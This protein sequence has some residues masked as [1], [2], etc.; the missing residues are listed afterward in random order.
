[1]A[2]L[3]WTLAVA[4]SGIGFWLLA[5]AIAGV[6]PTQLHELIMASMLALAICTLAQ[7]LVGFRLIMYEGPSAAYLAAIAV[8]AVRGGDGLRGITGGLI[9]AGAF[10]ALLG[11]LR[12][13]RLMLR[14]FT[15]LVSNLFVLVVTLAVLPDTLERA[16]G[17]THG[18]P[19]SAAAWV[20]SAAVVVAT[21]AA[22]S[23][24]R[25]APYALLVG[26]LAG[27]AVSL[28]VAG[29]PVAH[30]ESGVQAPPVLPWGAPKLD[31]GVALPFVVAGALAAL[32]TI[33]SGKVVAIHF[34]TSVSHRSTRRAFLVHGATQA[35]TAVL[36]NVL[37]NVS[38]LDTIGIMRVI[39]NFRRAP[40]IV[41]ALLMVTL[42]LI[43]P[44]VDVAAALPLSVSAALVAVILTL[45][46]LPAVRALA[47][48]SARVLLRVALPSL[49]PTAVWIAVGNSLPPTAQLIG[50][51]MLWGVL[52]A[53]V[54]E[55][56]VS[57]AL[58]DVAPELSQRA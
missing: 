32:N 38:R 46:I 23:V 50:N 55:R 3:L 10:V 14:V 43:R 27:T 51:P 40:L 42:S 30:I 7:V 53:V 19:G 6:P 28:A 11:V 36:G 45:V 25:L 9:I 22:R 44:A 31:L 41:A 34:A 26:L 52:L 29:V 35:G 49:V 18:L 33:A 12:V 58:T 21:L 4:P 16:I 13:D 17:A 54:L 2:G 5:G 56:L 20:S 48:M 8:V 15:P 47:R 1:V 39:G 57:P 37:G 24:T